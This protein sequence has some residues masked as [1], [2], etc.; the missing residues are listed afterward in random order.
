MKQ[1]IKISLLSVAVALGLAA[2]GG[3]SNKTPEKVEPTTFDFAP[4]AMITNLSND[5]IV[6][7]Y[8]IL[9]D[10]AEALHQAAQT[11]VNTPTQANLVAAQEAWIAARAPWEQGE[12]HIFGPID[13]MGIDP[14]L[15]SWPLATA[16]LN[17]VLATPGLINA[18]AVKA[19]NTDVQ[20][21]HTM[22][23]LLFGDG[24]TDNE[25]DIAELT[26]AQSTY[27]LATAEIFK[28]YT[29]QL[30]DAWLVGIDGVT[31]YQESFKTANNAIYGSNLAVIEELITGMVGIIN[32]VGTGK[33]ADPF[34]ADIGSIDTSK[35]ESQYSWNSLEDFANNITGVLNV[36]NGEFTGEADQ[37]GIYDFVAAGDKVLAD[38]IKAEIVQ[39]IAD[40]KAIPG[41][42][43]LPFRQAIA[44]ADGRVRI[45]TAIDSLAKL[46]KSLEIDAVALLKKWS[47]K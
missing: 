33:I 3:S 19:M 34:G 44:D 27:L 15:D 40:I 2:C 11:L 28:G 31:P 10:K 9:N 20:G 14:A 13:A 46:E 37:P 12:S 23:Y 35:V 45:Q 24:L 5:V 21:Y 1:Q 32:E 47:G 43:N 38:R 29:Q 30:E 36:Y 6:A 39:S 16:D 4:S 26:D 7:G 42:T 8:T 41:T 18:T 17:V 22:E 25:K